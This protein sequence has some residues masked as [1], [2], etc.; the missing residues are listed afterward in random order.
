M[1]LMN[2]EKVSIQYP[3]FVHFITNRYEKK[4]FGVNTI[5]AD[6]LCSIKRFIA[7]ENYWQFRLVGIWYSK[8]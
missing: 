5:S 4:F 3:I 1:K 2:L 7:C 6:R 8:R